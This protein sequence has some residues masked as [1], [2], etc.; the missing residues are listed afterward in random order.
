MWPRVYLNLVQIGASPN[1]TL[2]GR[3]MWLS[4]SPT[5]TSKGQFF[6]SLCQNTWAQVATIQ[7]PQAEQ[8]STCES[9]TQE[10]KEAEVKIK[11]HLLPLQVAKINFPGLA[12]TL[13]QQ[14]SQSE[15][16]L[17]RKEKAELRV[18]LARPIPLFPSLSASP[19]PSS[20]QRWP[21]EEMV[22]KFVAPFSLSLSITSPG[23][24]NL[25]SFF[26]QNSSQKEFDKMHLYYGIED[27]MESSI[28]QIINEL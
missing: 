16:Q 9:C 8:V 28:L 6:S 26:S 11:P 27:T 3:L 17:I 2:A 22:G 12:S 24:L 21:S 10:A 23:T 15:G 7:L 19:I 20:T 1:L 4:L 14:A 5:F 13:Q 25:Y 18:I